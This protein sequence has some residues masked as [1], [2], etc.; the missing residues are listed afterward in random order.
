MATDA[1]CGILWPGERDLDMMRGYDMNG[2]ESGRFYVKIYTYT[3]LCMKIYVPS[4]ICSNYWLFN[5]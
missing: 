5:S 3:Y 4:L 1:G 2:N